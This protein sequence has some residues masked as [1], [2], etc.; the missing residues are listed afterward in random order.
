[1]I[2]YSTSA[3]LIIEVLIE[4]SEPQREESMELQIN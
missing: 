4:W 3:D 2:I 1:M